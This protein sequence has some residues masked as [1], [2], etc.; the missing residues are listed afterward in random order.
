MK[1]ID[2]QIDEILK[3]YRE[4]IVDATPEQIEDFIKQTVQKEREEGKREGRTQVADMMEEGKR[5]VAWRSGTELFFANPNNL[6]QTKG[7]VD[8]MGFAQA[9]PDSQDGGKK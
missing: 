6:S 8:K 7:D 1:P 4:L 2:E 3:E 5:Y 9:V